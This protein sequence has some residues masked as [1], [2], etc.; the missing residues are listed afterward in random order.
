M[1]TTI[2]LD[3]GGTHMRAAV[4]SPIGKAPLRQKRIRSYA[5]EEAPLER[6][7][8]LIAEVQSPGE[9]LQALGMAV[10]GPVN[11]ETGVIPVAPNIPELADIPLK[12]ILEEK[13]GAPVL[14]GN[15][16]NLAALG[17]WRFGAGQ[18]HSHL[19]YLTISTGIGGGVISDDHLLQ[20]ARGL[21]AELGHV[22]IWPEGPICSCGQRGHLEAVSSGTAI[23]EF[24]A[25]RLQEGAESNLNGEPDARAVS[26][27]ARDGDPLALEA[28]QRAGKYLG[29]MVSNYLMIFNPT[30]VIFG[31]GVSQAGDL[32]LDPVRQ[33]VR[34]TVLSE[35]YLQDLTLT[36]AALGDDAGLYGALALARQ[37]R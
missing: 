37:N 3:I 33:W 31:G 10:P 7:L 25:R 1:K 16:A 30:L 34:K 12:D 35:D 24:V 13:T 8:N 28:F 18:G 5:E 14:L 32:L 22:T 15:D 36:R 23:S 2:A 19:I 6:L 26:A 29:L 27:A 4:F 20:G 11:P 17:E 21:G 9:T